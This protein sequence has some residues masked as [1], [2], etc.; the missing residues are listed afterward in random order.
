MLDDLEAD[1]RVISALGLCVLKL[2][3][4]HHLVASLLRVVALL[5]QTDGVLD[6]EFTRVNAVKMV[7]VRLVHHPSRDEARLAS[8]FQHPLGL[9]ARHFAEEPE[10]ALQLAGFSVRGGG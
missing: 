10:D 7:E 4:S 2:L 8:N 9:D 3:Q 1:D 5:D 6:A